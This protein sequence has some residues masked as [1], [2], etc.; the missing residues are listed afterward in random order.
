MPDDLARL[1][2]DLHQ[3]PESV[4]RESLA[5]VKKGALNVK[6]EWRDNAR[7]TAPP[8][9]P[10]YP[11][12]ITFDVERTAEGVEAE[13]GPDKELQQGAL[14]N[15]LEFG[16]VNNPPHNDGGRALRTEEPR[17]GQALGDLGEKALS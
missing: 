6:N 11:S 16:S 1:A 14:G 8:H 4:R 15:L 13:V 3:A 10:H 17:F 7:E 5:V 9:G 12:S 2:Q